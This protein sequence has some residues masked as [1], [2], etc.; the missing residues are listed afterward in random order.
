MLDKSNHPLDMNRI[1]VRARSATRR[2]DHFRVVVGNVQVSVHTSRAESV[3]ATRAMIVEGVEMDDK[4][5]RRFELW[6]QG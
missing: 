5:T 6:Q 3:S 2:E 4:E 1:G